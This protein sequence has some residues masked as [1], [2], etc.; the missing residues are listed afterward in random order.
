MGLPYRLDAPIEVINSKYYT[1]ADLNI[2]CTFR[3]DNDEFYGYIS[4][5][6]ENKFIELGTVGCRILELYLKWKLDYDIIYNR[7]YLSL[8]N[9]WVD[10]QP[11][12]FKYHWIYKHEYNSDL[13]KQFFID[14]DFGEFIEK[15]DCY[16]LKLNYVNHD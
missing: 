14:C 5:C 4:L 11:N 15:E 13:V 12:V 8:Y 3:N 1:K 9:I 2:S 10:M 6:Q 7:L 16:I